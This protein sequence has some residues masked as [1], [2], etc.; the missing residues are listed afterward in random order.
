MLRLDLADLTLF[1]H[2]AEAGSITAGAAKAN[3]ALAAA[4]TRLR[5]MEAAIGAKLAERGRLGI[6]LT[7]AGQTLLAHARRLLAEAERM[8]EALSA[9][10]GGSIGHIRMLSNTNALTEFLP[11]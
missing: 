7:P 3:L 6:V 8:H 9:Y 5:G 2:I 10:A 1:R 4:S 11:D